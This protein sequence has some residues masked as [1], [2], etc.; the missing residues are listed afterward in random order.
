MDD[1]TDFQI[2]ALLGC[3]LCADRFAATQ[4]AHQ[5]RPVFQG[6]PRA[7][8]LIAG[9]AP[10]ARVHRSGVPFSDPSGDRLRHGWGL[11]PTNFMILSV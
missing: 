9:Q 1:P 2:D 6:N 4:S 7:Q 3:R 8:I 11:N 5:P 10:G